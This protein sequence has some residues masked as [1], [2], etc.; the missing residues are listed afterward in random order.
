MPI[1]VQLRH[2][3]DVVRLL[4]VVEVLL[5][6]AHVLARGGVPV[7]IVHV[8]ALQLACSLVLLDNGGEG[9][10]LV[11]VQ[12]GLILHAALAGVLNHPVVVGT[13]L[14][15]SEA[16]GVFQVAVHG[17]G[18]VEVHHAELVVD[19]SGNLC[20]LGVGV[21]VHLDELEGE[22]AGLNGATFQVLMNLRVDVALLIGRLA[23][24]RIHTIACGTHHAEGVGVVELYHRRLL[25]QLRESNERGI[26]V[27]GVT[28]NLMVGL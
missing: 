17:I 21:A 27:I 5:V 14:G 16:A 19:G 1:G 10:N 20:A 12:H 28:D 11:A 6:E 22:L 13:G 9:D 23:T 8:G 26:Q 18:L 7:A 2:I 4:V 25:R 3:A 24:G 15:V